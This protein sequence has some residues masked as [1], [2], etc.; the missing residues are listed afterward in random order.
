MNLDPFKNRS[1]FVP[2]YSKEGRRYVA[3]QIKEVKDALA[4]AKQMK[5][6]R[7]LTTRPH[8]DDL[9]KRYTSEDGVTDVFEINKVINKG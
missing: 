1:P 5:S 2:S 6:K 8:P 3:S 7:G 9:I 4:Y